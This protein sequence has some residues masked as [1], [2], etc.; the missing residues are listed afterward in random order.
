MDLTTFLLERVAEDEAAANE[1]HTGPRWE[2][3]NRS[4]DTE[5]QRDIAADGVRLFTVPTIFDEHIARHDPARVLAQCE[6]VWRVV[7]L[8]GD[9]RPWCDGG[10]VET[11]T[12]ERVRWSAVADGERPVG[13]LC[14]TLLALAHP[15]AD[16]PDFDPAWRAGVGA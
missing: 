10:Y 16:H 5:P 2:S 3:W 9:D 14:P 12:H 11:A 1:A 13:E 4:W 6:A 8:H 15:Y 7:A